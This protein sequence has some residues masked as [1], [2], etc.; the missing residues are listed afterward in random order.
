MDLT[1]LRSDYALEK[2]NSPIGRVA[3]LESFPCEQATVEISQKLGDSFGENSY[4]DARNS[5]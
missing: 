5:S 1:R 2:P 3:L 4:L